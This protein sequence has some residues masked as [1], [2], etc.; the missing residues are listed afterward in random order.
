MDGL[1]A[2][3]SWGAT[4]Q[5]N[6]LEP[7]DKAMVSYFLVSIQ[8]YLVARELLRVDALYHFKQRFGPR[9]TKWT[10]TGRHADFFR[11]VSHEEGLVSRRFKG[12]VAASAQ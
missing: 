3:C 4:D 9:R 2:R 11:P 10:G 1:V 5:F 12:L 8:T 6:A 7:T